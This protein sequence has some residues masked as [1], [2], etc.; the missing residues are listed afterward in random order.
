MTD[1]MR[2][3]ASCCGSGS[4]SSGINYPDYKCYKSVDIYSL[5]KRALTHLMRFAA[6]RRRTCGR[7]SPGRLRLASRLRLACRRSLSAA[8]QAIQTTFLF[9]RIHI[10]DGINPYR[11]ERLCI[12]SWISY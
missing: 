9:S 4:R 10:I 6:S 5:R 7:S 3:A 2:L 8:L 11:Y 12:C 1:L